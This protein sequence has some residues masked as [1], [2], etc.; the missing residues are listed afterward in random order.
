[1]VFNHMRPLNFIEHCFSQGDISILCRDGGCLKMLKSS[2]SKYQ[3]IMLYNIISYY[4]IVQYS[5]NIF[6]AWPFH[7]LQEDFNPCAY[8]QGRYSELAIERFFGRLRSRQANAQLSAQQ[9]WHC[10][11]R[12]M[13]H[14]S[15][16]HAQFP[17]TSKDP[18]EPALTEKQF[19]SSTIWFS[20]DL[21]VYV[22][23]N[24]PRNSREIS[25][26]N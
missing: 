1:M 14:N 12:E 26:S 4:C 20:F 16:R 23:C 15:A 24:V 25:N 13:Q 19:L 2:L 22:V 10:S 17:K 5:S 8:K 7:R 9:F 11:Q 6:L 3:I 21:I 18:K